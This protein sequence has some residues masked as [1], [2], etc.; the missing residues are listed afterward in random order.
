MNKSTEYTCNISFTILYL[1]FLIINNW[2]IKSIE[3]SKNK[4]KL[5]LK[6]EETLVLIIETQ[7]M[8]INIFKYIKDNKKEMF[9]KKAKI[10]LGTFHFSLLMNFSLIFPS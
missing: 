6:I 4:K 2:F 8:L 9:Y 7:E 5:N 10:N 3:T 1:F